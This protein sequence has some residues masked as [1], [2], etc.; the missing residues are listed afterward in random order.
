MSRM[1]QLENTMINADYIVSVR[2]TADDELRIKMSDGTVHIASKQYWDIIS[3]FEHIVQVVPCDNAFDVAFENGEKYSSSAGF[4]CVTADG[5]V[6]TLGLG[7][8][9]QEPKIQAI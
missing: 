5:C 2:V 6:R 8:D 9:R 3:G 7:G 1:I 4:L